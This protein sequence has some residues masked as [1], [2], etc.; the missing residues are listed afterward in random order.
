MTSKTDVAK[1][2]ALRDVRAY[3]E[4]LSVDLEM[5]IKQIR[6]RKKKLHD[7]LDKHV[8]DVL[9][10]I[11]VKFDKE[12]SRIHY[13]IK[14]L[15]SNS[16]GDN[17]VHSTPRY[18]S[19]PRSNMSVN[20]THSNITYADIDQNDTLEKKRLLFS[21]GETSTET[22]TKLFGTY[23]LETSEQIAFSPIERS[24]QVRTLVIYI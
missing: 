24:V 14:K 21:A 20:T 18:Q 1:K 15:Q 2:R 23:T 12:V 10:D 4:V 9:N 5:T 22:L 7:E 6:D 11:K 13:A 8:A 16:K 3:E 19:T 17:S